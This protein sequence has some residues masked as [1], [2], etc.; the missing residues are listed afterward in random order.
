MPTEIAIDGTGFIVNGRPT[1]DGLSYKGRSIEGLL[2]NSR[3]VQAIFDDA[4]PETAA[5]WKYPDTGRWDPDRNTD[6]FCAALPL[7]R[8]H[9]LL[10]VTVGLQGGGSIYTPEVYGRYL[11]TAYE[12]NGSFKPAYFERL[13]RVLDAADQA[14]MV[15]IVN[16]FYVRQ[17]KR[18]DPPER[19]YDIA[20][21]VTDWLLRSGF[22]NVLVDGANEAAPWWKYPILE[23]G[24]VPRV[25]ETV[26]GTT[27][28]GRSL[29]V[30]VSTGGGK[31]IPT[32][33]WLDAEDFTTPHGN[34]CQPNQL[35]EKL[36]RVKETDAY[37]R[38]PR[39]IVVNE[40]SVFV[41][42]LEA[43][44]AEGCSWGFYCQGYGSDYQDR[45]D[46]KEHPR[47][48]EFD[49]LS[50]FQTVPVN[51]EINT[52]IKRAFFERLKTITAGA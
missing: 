49:A 37:K 45:M 35:R 3:M 27:L 47:E 18:L 44:L 16:Y 6:E 51:W 43:A 48:T 25:I 30:T 36:R 38:R 2:F 41:E 13:R 22:R 5:L 46:W 29:P 24:N 14:G 15:V 12:E 20:E 17:A 31:Q 19:V 33:A 32:D 9:G 23:P 4:C 34:G 21:R 10:A 11:N 1:Y 26:R 28:D 52:P 7:Y 39:P 50:G 42:N 8:K 40:D